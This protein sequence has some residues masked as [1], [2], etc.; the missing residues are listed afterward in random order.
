[1]TV[2]SSQHLAAHLTDWLAPRIRPSVNPPFVLGL[3][4]A[5][6]LGKT[7]TADVLSKS[8]GSEKAVH[9]KLDGYLH[10]RETRSRLG[11]NGYQLE[12]W[13]LCDALTSLEAIILHQSSV[14][15]PIYTPTG[16]VVPGPSVDPKPL[17]VLDGNL[18]LLSPDARALCSHL[19]FF[20][21]SLRTMRIMRFRRDITLERRFTP[22]VAEMV[23]RAELKALRNNIL[24]ARA[25]A[26]S[27]VRVF[28]FDR[29]SRPACLPS[30]SCKN[31]S[32]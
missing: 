22:P 9:I 24:P 26:D 15:V 17:I 12:G 20:G 1:M 25:H 4:G 21:A 2:L 6:G 10:T 3:G 8:L 28:G 23:W 16:L 14:A 30:A 11:A 18:I 7:H 13:R 32:L 19:L 31:T 5:A 29:Y 27:L